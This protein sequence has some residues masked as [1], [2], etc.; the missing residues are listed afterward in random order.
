M[1]HATGPSTT[2]VY[3]SSQQMHQKKEVIHGLL[4]LLHDLADLRFTNPIRNPSFIGTKIV[5]NQNPIK[6]I[7]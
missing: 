4:F 7:H 2:V 6:Y 5:L 1:G 3:V